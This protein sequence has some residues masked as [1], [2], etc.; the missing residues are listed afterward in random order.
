ML[1]ALATGSFVVQTD[2]SALPVVAVVGA[3]ATLVWVATGLSDLIGLGVGTGA[4]SRRRAWLD[5]RHWVVGPILALGSIAV[6]VLMWLPPV[7]QERS[8]HPGNITL[9]IRYFRD[10]HG[11]YPFDVGWNSLLS[12]DGVLVQGPGEVMRSLLGIVVVHPV[13]GWVVTIVAGLAAS[14]ALV[15]GIIQRN[16][17]P[18]GVGLASLAGGTA[19]VISA[20]HVVGLIFGYLL[21]WAVVL[22][23]AALI[24]PGLL[25]FPGHRHRHAAAPARP[26]TT[27][28]GLR[29]AL[30]GVAV[31][32]CV[33]AVVRVVAIPPLTEASDPAVGR[34][35]ALVVPMLQPGQRVFVGDAGAGTADTKLLDTERFIGLV[36]VLDERGYLPTVNHVWKTEF[37]PG[38][39]TD[40]H[41]SRLVSLSTWNPASP[42]MAGYV[43]RAGD[44]AVTVTDGSGAP[45]GPTP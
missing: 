26:V 13:M 21:V 38:Y 32:V 23:V 27:S 30:C 37:G 11:T 4:A 34:L 15:F 12:V 40:G 22:P 45:V 31:V 33:V 1:A 43:G 39:Q 2:I 41:E 6:V 28:T 17:F 42:S 24:A 10:H 7:L 19:V 9:I 44:M 20:T 35:A 29:L 5:R 14:T 25:A 18:I 8:N 16:R 3:V 36:N